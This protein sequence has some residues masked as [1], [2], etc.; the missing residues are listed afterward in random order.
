MKMEAKGVGIMQSAKI[1]IIIGSDN[2]S[3]D[4]GHPQ[5]EE[6]AAKAKL[7]LCII[8]VIEE[9]G[10]SEEEVAKRLRI[11]P[12]DKVSSILDGLQKGQLDKFTPG[13]L[14]DYVSALDENTEITVRD[15]FGAVQY[16][17]ATG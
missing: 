13:Q 5:L 14:V 9:R 8:G 1:E 15:D 3:T 6:A 2:V 16:R 10:L 4:S 11:L 7:M 17:V 12:P